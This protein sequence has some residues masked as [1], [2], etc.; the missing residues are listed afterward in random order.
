M[1][2]SMK[3]LA[4]AVVLSAMPV[5]TFAGGSPETGNT[6]YSSGGSGS[7]TVSEAAKTS[8]TVTTV[9]GSKVTVKGATTNNRG[10]ISG[11]VTNGSDASVAIGDA[12][13]AGLPASVVD[14]INAVNLGDLSSIPGID[15]TGL[16][17]YGSTVAVRAESGN[18]VISIYVSQ[19]PANGVVKVAFYNNYTFTWSLID[20]TVDPA[21]NI[22]TFTAPISGTAVVVG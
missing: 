12:A 16:T 20:A 2:K 6:N 9:S 22:V 17:A 13:I 18:Q 5:V 10:V 19:L 21:M 14:T 1:K 15:M 11:M 7:G 3:A 8:A 4:L